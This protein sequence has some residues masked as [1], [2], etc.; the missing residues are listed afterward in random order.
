[1]QIFEWAVREYS[2]GYSSGDICRLF[3]DKRRRHEEKLIGGSYRKTLKK[4][5]L[6][7]INSRSVVLELGPGSGSWTRAILKH[8]PEGRIYTCDINDQTNHLK[9]EKYSG[10]L[11]C[12]QV[13]DNEFSCIRNNSIDFFWSMGVLCHNPTP[14]IENILRNARPKMKPG[15]IACHHHG[16][17]E[18]LDKLNWVGGPPIEFKTKQDHDIWW[19]RNSTRTMVELAQKTGWKVLT[20]DLQLFRR[21]GIILLQNPD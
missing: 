17:W 5:V 8:I 2:S 13:K 18:K 16:D 9:P 21:D 12:Y 19:P 7:Y 3:P 20:P 6:P 14:D 11:V 4:A 10:R 15:G 1:M